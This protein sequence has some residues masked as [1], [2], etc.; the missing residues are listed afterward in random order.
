MWKILEIALLLY[1]HIPP[2]KQLKRFMCD[3][4]TAVLIVCTSNR[5]CSR[6]PGTRF[7]VLA[8]LPLYPGWYSF[9]A[10]RNNTR[11][12]CTRTVYILLYRAPGGGGPATTTKT[13]QTTAVYWMYV[14]SIKS[15]VSVTKSQFFF[16]KSTRIVPVCTYHSTSFQHLSYIP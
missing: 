5:H 2:H 13:T 16:L 8:A 14:S 15:Q 3:T 6:M 7:C 4:T 11:T 12:P 9:T 10:V 1:N